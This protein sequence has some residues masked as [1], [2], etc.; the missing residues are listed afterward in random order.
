MHA[1]L[2]ALLFVFGF[3]F[4]IS[5]CVLGP[6]VA[7]GSD[8]GHL[9]LDNITHERGPD[10]EIILSRESYDAA[11]QRG[12]DGHADELRYAADDDDYNTYD[13]DERYDYDD[14]E[15]YNRYAGGGDDDY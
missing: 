14:D 13:D 8:G 9:Q 4:H 7:R 3:F 6:T 2:V 15:S 11:R 1:A 5:L 12:G 10:G